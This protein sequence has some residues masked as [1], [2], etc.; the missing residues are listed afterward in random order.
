M[1]LNP[2]EV[3]VKESGVEVEPACAIRGSF[4]FLHQCYATVTLRDLSQSC[5][6]FINGSIQDPHSS[7]ASE[8]E[9]HIVEYRPLLNVV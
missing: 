2:A 5:Y 3:A 7:L 9:L 6:Y 1:S 4:L 8:K